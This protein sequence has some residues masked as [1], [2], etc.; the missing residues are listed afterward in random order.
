MRIPLI[1]AGVLLAAPAL[2]QQRFDTG[3]PAGASVVLR[4]S[5][6][7]GN[8]AA[9]VNETNPLPVSVPAG[10][11]SYSGCTVATMATV[12]LSASTTRAHVGLQNVSSRAAPMD[13]A[14]RWGG[15]PAV[16]D[17]GSFMLWW[18]GQANWGGATGWAPTGAL[19]C[20]AVAA[21][22]SS[23]TSAPLYIETN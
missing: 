9:P 1:M 5:G 12:C 10:A 8:A 18:G 23:G 21:P 3:L 14:C 19:T 22:G 20:I 13:V 11:G 4:Q 2:A 17:S 15:T 7:S 16:N 6:T